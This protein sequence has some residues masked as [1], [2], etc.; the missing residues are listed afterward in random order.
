[1]ANLIESATYEAGIYQFEV[2]DPL[3]GGPAG[4]D[5]LPHK[6]LANRTAWL[7]G[8]VDTLNTETDAHIGAGGAAHANATTSAAG[9]MSAA[10][11][12]ALGNAATAAALAA[13]AGNFTGVL[14][15][16]GYLRLPLRI[17]DTDR[18]LI[19]QW[20]QATSNIPSST[21]T[22]AFPIAFPVACVNIQATHFG[23][24]GSIAVVADVTTTNFLL[25]MCQDFNACPEQ[26]VSFAAFWLAIGY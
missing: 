8:Q 6:H 5:N 25:S 23:Y 22:V 17:A 21:K 3:Q 9:F 16:N 24:G 1:M 14:A 7:K 18:T 26:A 2:T 12:V 11:K 4:I 13:L 10:D 20:G 15:T 19:V